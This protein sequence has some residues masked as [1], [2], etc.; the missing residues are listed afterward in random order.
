MLNKNLIVII[1]DVLCLNPFDVQYLRDINFYYNYPF[2]AGYVSSLNLSQFLTDPRI[3]F[4]SI[5]NCISQFSYD[6]MF[7]VE[8][9]NLEATNTIY[10]NQTIKPNAWTLD[11][12][13]HMGDNMYYY[14]NVSNDIEL[15]MLD[16][17]INWKHKEFDGIQVIDTDPTFTILNLTNQ[18]GTGTADCAGGNNYGA[19]KSKVIYNYPVCRSGG[20]C[21]GSDIDRGFH[22]VLSRLQI[23][24][25]PCNTSTIHASTNCTWNKR[26]IINLS[27]GANVGPNY[28]NSSTGKYYDQLFKDLNDYGAIIFVA[29]GNSNVDACLWLYS[30]SD[31]VISVGAIDQQLATPYGIGR[32]GFSNWGTCVDIWNYGSSV[33]TAYSITDNTTIQYKSGTSF[34]SPLTA[35]LGVNLLNRFPNLNRYEMLQYLSVGI[36]N[37]TVA[38]YNCS[39]LVKHC[40]TSIIKNTRLNKYCN[41]LPINQCL[42][43]ECKIQVCI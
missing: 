29:A 17:G 12:F 28:I 20:S 39:N 23:Y 21:A 26:A 40:C 34:S 3:Q 14:P 35:G 36:Q 33:P 30:F 13:D 24:N 43:R 38:K 8:D 27:V 37:F 6:L 31:H 22:T 15:W 42:G 1:I 11:F 32:S 19:S 2:L 5:H 25:S 7:Q 18:H 16:T 4:S 9:C 41:S 10:Y